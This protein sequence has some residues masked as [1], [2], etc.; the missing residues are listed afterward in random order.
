MKLL[1]MDVVDQVEK[2]EFVFKRALQV[3]DDGLSCCTLSSTVSCDSVCG[4][5]LRPQKG[6]SVAVSTCG[7]HRIQQRVRRGYSS[8]DGFRQQHAIHGK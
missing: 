3:H 7:G 6:E 4:S 8:R 2:K 5:M 1:T